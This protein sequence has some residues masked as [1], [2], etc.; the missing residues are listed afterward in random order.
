ME[1]PAL[2][3]GQVPWLFSPVEVPQ[4]Q[5]FVGILDILVGQQRQV[6]TGSRTENMGGA[7]GSE[8]DSVMD[9]PTLHQRRVAD[10]TGPLVGRGSWRARCCATAGLMV[11]SVPVL[12]LTPSWWTCSRP[13][14]VPRLGK[15]FSRKKTS[16]KK[17]HDSPLRVGKLV[18]FQVSPYAAGFLTICRLWV[19][20]FSVKT[21]R[22]P[23]CR[24]LRRQVPRLR[25]VVLA[26]TSA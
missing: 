10:S 11:L 25:I 24:L 21:L 17:Q 2:Q 20:G 13:E 8:I 23:G 6:P 18:V 15:V 22:R 5:F 12:V 3:Q 7:S 1:T 4:I 19:H 26:V 16:C 9:T 14:R